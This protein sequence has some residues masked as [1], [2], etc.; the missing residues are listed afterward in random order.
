MPKFKIIAPIYDIILI[1]H[2]FMKFK[3]YYLNYV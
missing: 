1:L 3:N 2:L